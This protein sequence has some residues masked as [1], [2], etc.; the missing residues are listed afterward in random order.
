MKRSLLTVLVLLLFVSTAL[1]GCGNETPS[2]EGGEATKNIKQ[3]ITL[4]AKTEPPSLDP[5]IASDTTSGWVIDHLFE[6]L[7]TKNQKGEPVLGAASDVKISEDGKT[8]TFTIR[9]DAKWSDGDPVTAYDFEYAWK[10]VL[11]PKTG[12]P[13]A[14]YMYYIK[15]AEEY[16]KGKG[17]ADQ[18]GIKAL[19]DKTFQVELKAPLGY[20]DKLLTMWT[21]Y[22]VKKSLVES[23]PKWAADAKGY[24]SNGAYRLTEWKHNS[25]VVIEKNEHYWNKDQINMQKVTWKMVNDATTYYQMYKTGELDLI[26]TLPTDVIDQE[27]NNKEFKITPYF[28]TYMFM[29]NVDKPPFTNA[30]IRRAFAMAIDREA[31]VKNITKSG[32]KPAYAFVPYGVNTPKGDFREV[33]GSYFEENVKEAKQLLEEGMKE[34]G[35]TK[36]PEVTLMYNTA[37]NH[38]KIAEA[39]Q[40][41]LKT[42]LGVKVKLAN[43]EWKTYLETTQQSNFQMAR[44]GWVGVFVDP[45]VILDYYLGDSPNNRTN[46]VN[47]RFDDL[48]AKAKVEQDDQKRYELLHEAEKV[49]MTD[50]PFIPVYFYSQNYLTSPKFKGIVYPV[51]RY[52][53]VRWAKK[54]AE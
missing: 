24:V 40:E 46:W 8:Y 44:M 32:E 21:F 29:L 22:P 48:M 27:K 14:F 4:N 23:N 11:D 9:E 43:Q 17:S 10:R 35:W 20:F 6:G 41:M 31:I 52:P 42:N 49:L 33:G 25:E 47:K 13:F 7:Y 50:L 12:S 30:K 34:E 3:E 38:K 51:N 5:A 1:A 45:T 18:V 19:D 26:D 39:V 36:L 54:V 37:E 16:N 15:G 53:D 28:G 2:N